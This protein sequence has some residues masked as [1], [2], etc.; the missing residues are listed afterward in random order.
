MLLE[1][2]KQLNWVDFLLIILLFRVCY[3]GSKSGFPIEVFKLCGVIFAIYFSLHYYTSFSDWLRQRLPIVDEKAPLD[4]LDFL[5]ALVLVV[6]GYLSFVA[7]RAVFSRFLTVE[8]VP[9]LNKWGGFILGVARGALLAGLIVFLF[10]ISSMAY[11][12]ESV[13]RSYSGKYLLEAAPTVYIQ[14]WNGFM[15]KFMPKEKFNS[16]VSEVSGQVFLK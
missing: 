9:R 13:N 12:K 4:F 15:S 1:I 6:L 2:L 7:L 16:T 10:T 8:A 3:I 11:L 14:M 5:S